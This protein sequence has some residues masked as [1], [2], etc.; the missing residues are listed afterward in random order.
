[1]KFV[2]ATTAIAA[3]MLLAGCN[4]RQMQSATLPSA[5]ETTAH[6][7]QNFE[8]QEAILPQH[9]FVTDFTNKAIEILSNDKWKKVGTIINGVGHPWGDWVDGSGNF[10]ITSATQTGKH[11]IVEYKLPAT[12]PDFTYSAHMTSP[13]SVTTDSHGN[14]YEADFS[15][16]FVNEYAQKKNAVVATCSLDS[17]DLVTG[18]AVNHEGTVF[19]D[20]T[21]N[22]YYGRV[23]RY[24]GGL[25]GCHGQTLPPK[26]KYPY[27]M[28][29]DAQGALLVCDV[30]ANKVFV[31]KAPFDKIAG[32]FGIFYKQP[33]H[34]TINK[35]NRQAY[36]TQA[37]LSVRVMGY[38]R[39][40]PLATLDASKGLKSPYGAVDGENFVP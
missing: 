33:I 31:L 6:A 39:A 17:G 38:P 20:Y 34:V 1:M 7:P 35:A 37:G 8:G 13:V 24:K 9:L 15:G 40:K 4:N 28:A 16:H 5:G 11:T 22:Q 23:V 19:I 36:V 12:K 21:T 25:S 27:G 26:F 30:T 32:T 14:V 29:I 3:V 10:Y 2:T 18:V